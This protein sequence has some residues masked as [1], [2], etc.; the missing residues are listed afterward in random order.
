MTERK[1]EIAKRR[2]D[3]DFPHQV[4]ILVPEGGAVAR[5][6]TVQDRLASEGR[7]N[8]KKLVP[9]PIRSVA[10]PLSRMRV[11]QL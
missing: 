8:R 9:Q 7:E 1:G 6:M 11:S 10:A 5:L 3:R 2:I 4:A